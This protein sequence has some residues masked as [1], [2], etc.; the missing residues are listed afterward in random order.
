MRAHT[1]THTCTC[2]FSLPL[3]L[4]R[5][6]SPSLALSHTNTHPRVRTVRTPF[7]HWCPCLRVRV[8]K[9]Q[10]AKSHFA[11]VCASTQAVVTT[12]A[13]TNATTTTQTPPAGPVPA[14]LGEM[15]CRGD[16]L[17]MGGTVTFAGQDSIRDRLNQ[18]LNTSV[19]FLDDGRTDDP[20]YSEN[21]PRDAKL[22][23]AALG[24][25]DIYC[26]GL[27]PFTCP[28]FPRPGE[29]RRECTCAKDASFCSRPSTT[30]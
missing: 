17:I 14:I 6:L 22:L 25:V 11:E 18:A 7:T 27:Q 26:S 8:Q 24:N 16:S 19:L 28:V 23:K 15:T 20:L 9:E 3:S 29:P 5:S 2:S 30:G 21:C 4:S 13:T 12:N 1:R 10:V